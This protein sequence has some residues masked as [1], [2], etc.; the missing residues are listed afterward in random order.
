MYQLVLDGRIEKFVLSLSRIDQKLILKALDVLVLEPR[1][2]Q[3]KKLAGSQGYRMRAG[4]Y[5]ILYEISDSS[6]IVTVYKIGHRKD[7][8]R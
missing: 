1:N 8:Y 4:T 7:V 6:K 2:R 3:V 5:R